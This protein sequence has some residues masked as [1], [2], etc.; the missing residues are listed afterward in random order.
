MGP[1]YALQLLFIEKR[2]N[3]S[4]TTEATEKI[5]TDLES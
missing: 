1:G 2:A 4:T 5:T 3:N